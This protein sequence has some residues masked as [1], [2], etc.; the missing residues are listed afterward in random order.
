MDYANMHVYKCMWLSNRHNP[1]F[2]DLATSLQL[3]PDWRH[4]FI[5]T[6]CTCEFSDVTHTLVTQHIVTASQAYFCLSQTKLKLT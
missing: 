5:G 4:I 2:Q 3:K 6:V 1:D